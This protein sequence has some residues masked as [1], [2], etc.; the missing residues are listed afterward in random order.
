MGTCSGRALGK[1]CTE[2]PV[3]QL[4]QNIDPVQRNSSHLTPVSRQEQG[5]L[6]S[7]GSTDTGTRVYVQV[8]Q[9]TLPLAVTR[10]VQ[11]N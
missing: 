5:M 10:G 9:V 1:G 3:Q 11:F 8:R 2:V 7:E 6:V 4:P